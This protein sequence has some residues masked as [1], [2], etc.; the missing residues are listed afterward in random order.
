MHT[1]TTRAPPGLR[2]LFLATKT[3]IAETRDPPAVLKALIPML[4]EHAAEMKVKA[5]AAKSEAPAK[6]AKKPVATKPREAAAPAAKPVVRRARK[7]APVAQAA[8]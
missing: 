8:E 2:Q 5:K 1:E 3:A 7:A 6:T 4:R